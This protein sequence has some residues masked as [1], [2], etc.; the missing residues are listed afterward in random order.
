MLTNLTQADVRHL[1]D[2]DAE[3]GILIRKT[4]RNGCPYNKPVGHKPSQDGYGA[5][6]IGRTIY[7]TH[8]I[9]W[10]WYYGTWPQ[11]EINHID[12]NRINNKIENLED[13]D[14]GRNSHNK[15]IYKN[16]KMGLPGVSIHKPNGKFKAQIQNNYKKESLG[17]FDTAEEAFLAYQLAKI[18]YHPES[19]DAKEY[20][21]ELTY[22]S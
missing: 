14:C 7:R 20:L 12:R 8:R 21:R 6:R 13:V 10:L 3:N 5:V 18:K 4:F 9:I 19:P 2:Y 17:Y 22:A 11:Y 1:F 15:G 16:N